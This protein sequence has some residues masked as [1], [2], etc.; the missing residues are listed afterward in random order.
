M[1]APIHC[2]PTKYAITAQMQPEIAETTTH[3]RNDLRS[4]S[5]IRA[6]VVSGEEYGFWKVMAIPHATVASRQTADRVNR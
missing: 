2:E 1:I 5:I 3:R 6:D 4:W